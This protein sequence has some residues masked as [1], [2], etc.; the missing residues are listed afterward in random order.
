MHFHNSCTQN[1][2]H[3]IL[4]IIT[5]NAHK[6][7]CHKLL[8]I[9]VREGRL[10]IIKTEFSGKMVVAF[11]I[12]EKTIQWQAYFAMWCCLFP[13]YICGI[14]FLIWLRYWSCFRNSGYCSLYIQFYKLFWLWFYV[15]VFLNLRFYYNTVKC[16]V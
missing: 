6:E 5:G 9:R 16:R 11:T 2:D 8:L 15:D 14:K 10:Y 4:L 1:C 7:S 12:E 13:I 3:L